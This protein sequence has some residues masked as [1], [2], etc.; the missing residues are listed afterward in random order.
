LL[1]RGADINARDDSGSTPLYQ[2]AAWDRLDVID[3]L[4]EKGADAALRTKEGMTPL[5]AAVAN[6]HKSAAERLRRK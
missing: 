6:E 2:A 4:L 1:E 5:E 3:L